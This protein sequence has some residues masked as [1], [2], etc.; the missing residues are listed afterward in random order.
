MVSLQTKL[1]LQKD[2]GP[3]LGRVIFDV[4]PVLLALDDCVASAHANVVDTH[5]RFVTSPEFELSLLWGHCQ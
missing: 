3:E 4:E 1:V 2:D 5:L